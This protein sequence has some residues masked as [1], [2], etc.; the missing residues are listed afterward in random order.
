MRAPL[1]R[2]RRAGARDADVLI[3]SVHLPGQPGSYYTFYLISRFGLS[4][5][6]AQ[7]H[8]F[9]FLGA[10]AVGTIVGGPIGDRFG[11]RRVI[12]W[13]ILGVLPVHARASLRGPVLDARAPSS[14]AS[15]SP[16]RSRAIIVYAQELVPGRVG[17]ISGLFFGLAFGIGG[18]GAAVLGELA[19][20]TSI[21]TVYL[22]CS[23]L[24]AI[25]ILGFWL[26]NI[27]PVQVR[28]T[29]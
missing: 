20:R 4:V 18:I 25:G 1:P 17:T 28:R 19:D 13:S 2:R 12:L 3:F 27:E 23:Y 21:A 26:P 29:S 10:V 14:S 15:C 9:L 5:R 16:P 7:M 8:L 6:S 22:V 24:P 11:R